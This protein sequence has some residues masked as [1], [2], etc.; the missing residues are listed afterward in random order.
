MPTTRERML[1]THA[2]QPIGQH[3]A[4]VGETST[5]RNTT[6]TGRPHRVQKHTPHVITRS[7]TT[8]LSDG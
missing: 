2:T 4:A 3:I 6:Q 7:T 5:T 1:V 8:K